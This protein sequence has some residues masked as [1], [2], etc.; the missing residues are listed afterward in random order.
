[1]S[2]EI[3]VALINLVG[4]YILLKNFVSQQFEINNVG[5]QR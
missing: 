1:M 5:S 2:L 3:G 4:F